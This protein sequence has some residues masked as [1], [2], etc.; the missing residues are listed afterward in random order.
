MGESELK[1]LSLK[2][3][4]A[5]M[6]VLTTALA[7][8]ADIFVSEVMY[9]PS[10]AQGSDSAL[11][12]IEVFNN[13]TAPVNLAA[14]KFNG[15][16]FDD[17]NIG[18]KEYIII[19]RTLLSPDGQSFEGYYGNNDSVWSIADGSYQALDG[20]FGSV[21]TNG[22]ITINLTD[23]TETAILSYTND[24]AGGDGKTAERFN[25]LSTRLG[26]SKVI[27]GTPGHQN[28][29]FDEIAPIAAFSLSSAII[30]E[31]S[32]VSVNATQSSDNTSIANF[33][34]DF[35]DGNISSSASPLIT[36]AYYNN[37]SFNVTVT[38][39]D[40]AG[41]ANG[42]QRELT[43]SDGSPTANFT[44]SNNTPVEDAQ[45]NFTGTSAT[46]SDAIVLFN[47]DFGDGSSSSLQNSSHIFSANGTFTVTFTI[48]DS[49]GSTDSETRQI[50]VSFA[51]DA[52][53]V[54]NFSMGFDEDTY[55]S[56]NNTI[57][58][59]TKVSDEEDPSRNISWAAGTAQN[60]TITISSGNILNVTSARDFFGQRNL[61]LTATDSG[62]K[63]TSIIVPI[64]INSINDAPVLQAIANQTVAQGQPLT[65]RAAASDVENDTLTFSTTSSFGAINSTTGLFS[66]TPNAS[67]YRNFP[68]TL[69]ATDP[70]GSAANVTANIFVFST[71]NISDVSVKVGASAPVSVKE[72]QALQ[73]VQPA[74]P[75]NVSVTVKNTGSVRID[76]P[77]ISLQE[78]DGLLGTGEELVLDAGAAM[79]KQFTFSIDSLA[80]EGI[81]GFMVQAQG[82]DHTGA[83]DLRSSTF[84]FSI[85]VSKNLDDLIIE[86]LSLSNS[87]VKCASPAVL[88]ANI[89]N[90]GLK[91]QTAN[92]QVAQSSLGITSI[93]NNIVIPAS[94][95]TSVLTTI[96][97]ANKPAGT[98]LIDAKLQYD[99]NLSSDAENITLSII[100]CEPGFSG[101]IPPVTISE[102][103]FN[104]SINLKSFFND[105]NNDTLSFAALEASNITLT[106]TDGK[107]NISSPSDFNGNLTLKFTASDGTNTTYSNSFT[108][109]ILPVNDPP[110]IAAIPARAIQ[111]GAPFAF[112]VSAS[113]VENDLITFTISNNA[114]LSLAINSSG[115]ISGF[116]P[117][118]PDVG[119]VAQVNV[120]ANDGQ[121]ASTQPFLLTVTNLND[122]PQFNISRQLSP[123]SMAEDTQDS[124]LNLSPSFFDVGSTSLTFEAASVANVG[125]SINQS[126]GIATITP[127]A[128]FSGSRS[129][130]FRASD[131][132][133]FSNFSNT[134]A[135]TVTPSNDAPAFQVFSPPSIAVVGTPFSF[136][137]NATDIDND[138]LSFSDNTTL[139]DINATTA[140]A[141]FMPSSSDIGAHGIRITASDGQLNTSLNASLSFTLNVVDALSITNVS[142]SIDDGAFAQLSESTILQGLSPGKTLKLRFTATNHL[143]DNDLSLVR[144]TVFL[145]NTT[146]TVVSKNADISLLPKSSSQA[147]TIDIGALPFAPNNIYELDIDGRGQFNQV[148]SQTQFSSQADYLSQANQILITS[149]TPSSQ[150]LECTRDSSVDVVV[151]NI[152]GFGNTSDVS[153]SA[154]NQALGI[155]A[156]TSFQAIPFSGTHTFTIPVS[157]PFSSAPGTY[158]IA[159]TANT[160]DNTQAQGS[161]S[162]ILQSCTLAFSPS[163]DPVISSKAGQQFAVTGLR[164]FSP[165]SIEWRLDG[166]NQTGSFN[167]TSF[168][169][170][171]DNS[172]GINRHS[173]A[174][175]L[176]DGKDNLVQRSWILTTT[177]FPIAATVTTSPL[178]SSLNETQLKNVT[179]TVQSSIQ[180]S[181]AATVQFLAPIDLSGIVVLDGHINITSGIVAVD[182]LNEFIALSKPARITLTG[183]AYSA[184]PRIFFSESF[185]TNPSDFTIDCTN[186]NSQCNLISFTP[187]P[188]TSGTVVFNVSQFSSYM[189]NGSVQQQQLGQNAS[190]PV[191]NAGADQAVTSGTAVILDGSSSRDPDGALTSFLWSQV[192]GPTTAITNASQSRASITPAIESTYIFQLRVTDNSGL[193]SSDTVTIIVG[194]VSKLQISDLDVKVEDK[195]SKDIKNGE[196]ISRRAKPGDKIVFDIEVQNTFSSSTGTDIEDIEAEVTIK[197][198]DDGDDLEENIDLE[199]LG[200]GDD[201]SGTVEF[202]IPS[203][204][205]EEVYDVEIKVDGDADN[206]DTQRQTFNIQLEVEKD[207]DE[208]II[209]R[210][211]LSQAKVACDRSPSLSL[212][213]VNIGSNDQD[214][215]KVAIESTELGISESF[216]DIQL[217]EGDQEE[218][219]T[220]EDSISLDISDA[221]LPG[222]YQIRIKAFVEN[223]KLVDDKVLSLEVGKCAQIQTTPLLGSKDVEVVKLEP[224][225]AQQKLPSSTVSFRDSPEY[226]ALLALAFL[227]LLVTAGLALGATLMIL[228]KKSP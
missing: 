154:V 184:T 134:V 89:T 109:L 220:F 228:R 46:P 146:T 15:N 204:V 129:V 19:A 193:T 44:I 172:S 28:S 26:A 151:K 174:V 42:T 178:L 139:F 153:V 79:A 77:S 191:A 94:T 69:F 222:T 5:V 200:T 187:A 25:F 1:V 8:T 212:R 67:H 182:S 218:D 102:G 49:D 118:E 50:N 190:T 226:L 31:A 85:N 162:L 48:T 62:N 142:A 35:G 110:A 132:S 119:I 88:T 2:A 36:H 86:N 126:T 168:S 66:F 189:V 91:S 45:V 111:Q 177:S 185:T 214:E 37:G 95:S 117:A 41:L 74:T 105:F 213:V 115:F 13:G 72:G 114:S 206:G 107:A 183:L 96:P 21:L 99:F 198:I 165:A 143:T 112:Q 68:L 148:I 84:N 124:S 207:K 167:Q 147:V 125:I 64:T 51:N 116:T 210:A 6:L 133:L 17:A 63:S 136:S 158:A 113:D 196:K 57:N 164:D 90:I 27:N 138:T 61:T 4:L 155:S 161:A 83:G 137:F 127:E 76:G 34:F 24:V 160:T 100:N 29:I 194:E 130:A 104:D 108:V 180:P 47:W 195:T 219:I 18:S 221:I 98:Y 14:W 171:P 33:T 223:S 166:K 128:N 3:V 170:A 60:L 208:L 173:V 150:T 211:S 11:E 176:K 163:A 87:S 103:S 205:D 81:Q 38:I 149:I 97:A 203:I 54:Q 141:S 12:W 39:S 225:K 32:S 157:V 179:L 70:N 201:D 145:G 93:T 188:T 175:S 53:S 169:Y 156:A 58:L 227:L 43:V 186:I 52:P 16:N 10:T 73:N 71:M 22:G 224:S 209:D 121:N 101:T 20:D 40:E 152:D 123:V 56:Q 80:G 216:D 9:D 192:S 217:D 159:I 82:S 215:V 59:T 65:I 23:G 7:A 92:L 120:T 131:G 55:S 202:I 106:I 30:A 122:A 78:A 199:D 140:L 181:G 135:I 197:D 144:F 75:V